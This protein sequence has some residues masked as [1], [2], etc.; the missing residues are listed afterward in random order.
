MVGV[1]GAIDIVEDV[2]HAE[3]QPVC[4]HLVGLA[5]VVRGVDAPYLPGLSVPVVLIVTCAA[6]AGG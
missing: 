2:I 5:K 6:A 4:Q 1:H 3:L